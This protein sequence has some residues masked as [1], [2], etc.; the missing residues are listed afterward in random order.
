M[1][2][3]SPGSLG[4]PRIDFW[5][6]VSSPKHSLDFAFVDTSVPQCVDN[7]IHALA[8]DEI[9]RPFAPTMWEKPA[10]GQTLTQV[11]FGG[12]HSDIGGSFQDTASANI[13][14]TWM[15]NHLSK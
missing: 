6:E 10:Q 12:C 9:R 11:W 14:L 7:A 13:T 2:D 3:I 15:V 1:A 4:V 5:H 8:L